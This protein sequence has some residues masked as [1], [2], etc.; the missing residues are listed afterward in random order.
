ME[1]VD[2]WE[3]R[4]LGGQPLTDM[5]LLELLLHDCTPEDTRRIA[6]AMRHRSDRYT[7]KVEENDYP[8]AGPF[9]PSLPLP[10]GGPSGRPF[11]ERGVSLSE[12]FPD[13]IWDEPFWEEQLAQYEIEQQRA[14]HASIIEV[15]RRHGLTRFFQGLKDLRNERAKDYRE[16]YHHEAWAE[17][18]EETAKALDC[19]LKVQ[20]TDPFQGIGWPKK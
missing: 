19:F 17:T 12:P 1:R 13:W 11:P 20:A 9:G 2:Y 5:E 16:I 14:T 8:L 15:I 3:R 10:R 18:W 7:A 4:V 6:L